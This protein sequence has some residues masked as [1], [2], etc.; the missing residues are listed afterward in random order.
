M[1]FLLLPLL[2]A[3]L[4]P[5][6]LSA[7]GETVE[8]V[9]A[10][11]MRAQPA[12]ATASRGRVEKGDRGERLDRSG[13]WVR[14]RMKGGPEGWLRVWQVGPVAEGE[15]N[16]LLSGL[17]RFSRDIAGLFG[18]GDDGGG[19]QTRVT[20]TIGVRGLDGGEFTEAAPDAAALQRVRGLSAGREEAAS[21]ARA[22]GLQRRELATPESGQTQ[23]WEDW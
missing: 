6:L 14:V 1:K 16:A 13:G 3:A 7:A 15:E 22:A 11:E 23:N 12:S 10:T 9:A 4:V 21:F 18:S 2:L 19:E 17:K 5:T 20:A 8:V